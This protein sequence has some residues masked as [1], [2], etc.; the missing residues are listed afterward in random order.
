MRYRAENDVPNPIPF[1]FPISRCE[2]ISFANY[3]LNLLG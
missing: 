2:V 1:V 3:F